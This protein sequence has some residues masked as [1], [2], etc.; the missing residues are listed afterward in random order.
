M[1]SQGYIFSIYKAAPTGKYYLLRTTRREFRNA[2]QREE[3][4][5]VQEEANKR[6][7]LLTH[8]AATFHPDAKTS[9]ELIGELQGLPIG[10]A[11]YEAK[12][13]ETLSIY[14]QQTAYGHPWIILGTAPSEATFLAALKEDE[15]LLALNPVGKLQQIHATFV[16]ATYL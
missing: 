15:D 14:Y 1:A 16:T 8:I 5:A 12:D 4:D 10:N 7:Q 11:L 9:F 6:V 2:A 3:D 13:G